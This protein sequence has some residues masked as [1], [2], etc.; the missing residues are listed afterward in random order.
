LAGSETVPL[1]V[2]DMFEV[3]NNRIMGQMRTIS[4]TNFNCLDNKELI[5][6]YV[7]LLETIKGK[8]NTDLKKIK[9]C[10]KQRRHHRNQVKQ[11]T[12]NRNRGI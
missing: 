8:M 6:N 7:H 11:S 2:H 1:P 4:D 5:T 3:M 9:S 12:A 10:E